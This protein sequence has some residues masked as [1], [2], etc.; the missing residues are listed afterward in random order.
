MGL[1]PL[2]ICYFCQRGDRLYTLESDVYRRQIRTY[3]DGLHAEWVNPYTAERDYR[4]FKSVLL[5]V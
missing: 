4:R 3:K 2:E 1:R 5:T